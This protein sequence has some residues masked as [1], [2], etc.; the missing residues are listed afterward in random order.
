M[1]RW[2]Q[3][4]AECAEGAEDNGHWVIHFFPDFSVTTQLSLFRTALKK[5]NGLPTCD[6][7]YPIVSL[8]P[9][10]A[11]S[12]PTSAFYSVTLTKLLGYL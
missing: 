8:N 1:S 3:E 11:S 7:L 5:K 12:N 4:G 6:F 10:H 9:G 2:L